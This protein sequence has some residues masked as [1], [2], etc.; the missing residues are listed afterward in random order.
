MTEL[1]SADPSPMSRF[2]DAAY[3]R[4]VRL[5]AV[6]TA[7]AA[8]AALFFADWH[9]ALALFVG[10]LISTLN[11]MWLHR[12]ADAMTNRM[13]SKGDSP[14]SKFR[15]MLFFPL[16]YLLVIAAVY[17][18]LKSYPGVLVSFIAGLALPVMALIG[19]SVYEAVVLSKTDR[20]R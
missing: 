14:P 8:V 2:L 9:G 17:A 7:V 12:G 10:S 1:S 13:L 4:I 16:R 19:E 6:L 5:A 18:I 15:V 20:P 3:P 11:L